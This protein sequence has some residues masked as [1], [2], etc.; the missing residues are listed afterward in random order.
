ETRFKLPWE[1]AGDGGAPPPP[2]RAEAPVLSSAKQHFFQEIKGRVHRK[3]IERLNLSSLDKLSR[4]Q[5]VDAIRKV[6][7]DLLAAESAPLNFEEREE[8]VR[9][10]LDEIFGLGQ[11]EPVMRYPEVWGGGRGSHWRRI[12]KVRACSSTPTS[13]CTSSAT[14][15]SRRPTSA[16]R[17]TGTC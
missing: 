12:R 3:L 11:I 2:L 7:H 17:T 5:V 13:R 9:Q 16:S 6:V 8:L 14:A 4:D 10:V 15:S 1:R